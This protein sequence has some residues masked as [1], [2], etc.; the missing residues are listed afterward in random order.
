MAERVPVGERVPGLR[1]G[2]ICAIDPNG[3]LAAG[4]AVGHV[5]PHSG[6]ARGGQC[7]PARI[8]SQHFRSG[9]GS[10]VPGVVRGVRVIRVVRGRGVLLLFRAHRNGLLFPYFQH[11]YLIYLLI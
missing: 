8:G 9:G 7:V 4:S 3:V 11:S 10:G 5:Q 1:G 6:G 2:A